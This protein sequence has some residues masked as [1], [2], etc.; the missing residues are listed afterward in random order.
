MEPVI[1]I[2][3]PLIQENTKILELGC[4]TGR[5]I[6]EL[7]RRYPKLPKIHAV[8]FF[9]DPRKLEKG[10]T[11]E[12]QNL[13]N[14]KMDGTFDLI[15]MNQVLEHIKNFY[16]L[17]ESLKNNLSKDGT[18]YI[19]V[20]NRFGFNNT[21]KIYNSADGPHVMLWDKEN[22]EFCL[23]QMG[24]KT[25]FIHLYEAPTK[26]G[27]FKHLPKLLRIQNPNLICFVQHK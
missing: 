3:K 11:F 25:K 21:A 8:D 23:D 5:L 20:P 13:E 14:F 16:G 7:A 17:L 10:I 19:A 22:L 4:G 12:K 18:I 1:N 26:G 9:V 2:I 24:Y 27:I 15:I 6:N